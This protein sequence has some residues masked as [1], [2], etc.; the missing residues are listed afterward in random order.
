MTSLPE[1][2]GGYTFIW[3]KLDPDYLS[4]T[5]RKYLPVLQQDHH[6]QEQM[7]AYATSFTQAKNIQAYVSLYQRLASPKA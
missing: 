3:D 2:G 7:K 6:K 5:L 1:I 4:Q